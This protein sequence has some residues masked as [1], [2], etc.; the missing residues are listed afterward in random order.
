MLRCQSILSA[1][2]TM[3]TSIISR[4]DSMVVSASERLMGMED[5]FMVIDQRLR[6]FSVQLCFS[7]E[8]LRAVYQRA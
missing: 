6:S 2:S 3:N 4:M 8:V 7:R 5:G 1:E